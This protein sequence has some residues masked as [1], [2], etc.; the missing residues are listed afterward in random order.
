MK[1][2]YNIKNGIKLAILVS[3]K[4]GIITL[5]DKVITG[6]IVVLEYFDEL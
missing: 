6:T 2:Y 3:I 4:M 1:T 5:R